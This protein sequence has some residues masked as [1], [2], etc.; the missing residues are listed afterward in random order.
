MISACVFLTP[1][2]LNNCLSTCI[3]GEILCK[4]D[5]KLRFLVIIYKLLY[6]RITFI[7]I[8]LL[9]F[10]GLTARSASFLRFLDHKE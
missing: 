3:F 5:S 6:V 7:F 2:D 4:Y 9:F 8:G 10:C 1:G